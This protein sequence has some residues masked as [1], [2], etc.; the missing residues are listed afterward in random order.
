MLDEQV[1]E[2]TI[3]VEQAKAALISAQRS[4][5]AAEISIEEYREGVYVQT[6]QELK[7]T[8]ATADHQLREVQNSLTQAKR[9]AR[10]GYVSPLQLAGEEAAVEHA[11][12]TLGVA[13]RA[14]QVLEDYTRPKMLQELRS[15]RDAAQATLCGAG[16]VRFGERTAE[17]I[18]GASRRL[19][20]PR[21]ARRDGHSRQ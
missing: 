3:L 4:V 21:P 17:E 10:R 2:Q 5:T 11:R 9:L 15:L 20:D 12:L 14:V 8:E 7:L 16:R 18:G 1:A 13:Q 6:R 19:P